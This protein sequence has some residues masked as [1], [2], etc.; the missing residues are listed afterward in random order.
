MARGGGAAETDAGAP[1][2]RRLHQSQMDEPYVDSKTSGAVKVAAGKPPGRAAALVVERLAV[3][4][5]GPAG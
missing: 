5:Q 4:G 1:E 2:D 3:C